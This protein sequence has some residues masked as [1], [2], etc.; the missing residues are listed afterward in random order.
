MDNHRDPAGSKQSAL[1]RPEYEAIM[2]LFGFHE[3]SQFIK[4]VAAQQH[5]ADHE[6]LTP[7]RVTGPVVPVMQ[8]RRPAM[9]YGGGRA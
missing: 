7:R 8:R 9:V 5:K 1:T 3:V 2:H 6:Q 4:F